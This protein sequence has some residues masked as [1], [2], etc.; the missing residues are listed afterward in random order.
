MKYSICS[1]IATGFF[2]ISFI[3]ILRADLP[4]N[5]EIVG[6]K[7]NDKS[8]ITVEAEVKNLSNKNIEIDPKMWVLVASTN[9]K[10]HQDTTDMQ[11]GAPYKP[12]LTI[13]ADMGNDIVFCGTWI[14][15]GMFDPRNNPAATFVLAP[16]DKKYVS[17]VIDM[18]ALL[19]RDV[20]TILFKDMWMQV[21]LFQSR[22]AP[23]LEEE[24]ELIKQHR[25]LSPME[26]EQ[27]RQKL[28]KKYASGEIT[29]GNLYKLEKPKGGE[30]SL[31]LEPIK[32]PF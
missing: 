23:T 10:Y 12:V 20:A 31:G 30:S 11:I 27:V 15:A 16:G 21:G 5:I 8:Q 26:Y 18:H 17:V 1:I 3:S 9:G 7:L 13:F 25:L 24:N 19:L 22:G 28:L 6:A 2:G 14:G 29:H 4:A 32:A